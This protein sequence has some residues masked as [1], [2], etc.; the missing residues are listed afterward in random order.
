MEKTTAKE[1]LAA[2]KN[3]GL[4]LA[5]AESCTGGLA[6]KLITDIPGSS[7][8]FLGGVVSYSNDVKVGMLGVSEETLAAHGAVSEET[9]REMALGAK[10]RLCADIGARKSLSERYASELLQSSV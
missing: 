4:K 7:D 10:E 2:L 8:V 3:K 5:C 9:A 1:A 6:A